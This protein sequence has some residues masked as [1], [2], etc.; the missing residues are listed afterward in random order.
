[1]KYDKFGIGIFQDQDIFDLMYQNITSFDDLIV[2]GSEDIKSMVENGDVKINLYTE[3]QLTKQDFDQYNQQQWFI[4]EEY[5]SFDVYQFCLDNCQNEVEQLRC[6]EELVVYEKLNLIPVLTVLKYI[7]DTLRKN[8][9][10]WGVGRGSSVSS[11]VLYKI[12]VHKINSLKFN[13]DYREFLRI[14]ETQ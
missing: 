5:K 13:L 1:M 3:P 6:F 11:Y 12:G 2:E 10:V 9:I 14:G 4:P 7:V 8:N